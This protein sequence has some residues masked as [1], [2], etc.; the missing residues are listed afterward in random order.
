MDIRYEEVV[1]LAEQLT[2]SEQTALIT[3]LLELARYRQLTKEERKALF[4]ASILD[5]AVAQEPSPRREDWYDDD[6]R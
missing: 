2:P 6:G 4:H 3:H 1:H 5:V